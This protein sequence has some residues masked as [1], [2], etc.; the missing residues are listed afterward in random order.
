MR[1]W[2]VLACAALSAACVSYR[3]AGHSFEPQRLV[4]AGWT[5]TPSVPVLRQVRELDCGPVAT[6]MLLGYWGKKTEP[7][8]LRAEAHVGPERALSAGTIRDLVKA[9]GLDAYLVEGEV[10][11][12]QRELAAGRPV[13]VGLAKPISD[14]KAI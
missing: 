13:L 4:E 11:D 2:A 1:S 7:D 5:A 12:L 6:A 14:K 3:G 9:R 10:D 8:A